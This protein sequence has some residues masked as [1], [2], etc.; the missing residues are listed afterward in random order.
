MAEILFKQNNWSKAT[1]CYLL[2]SFKFEDNNSVATD[3]I[4]QLYQ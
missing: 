4:T 1:S 2:A 3:E